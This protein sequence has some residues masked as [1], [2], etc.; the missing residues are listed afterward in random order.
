M[1]KGKNVPLFSLFVANII[2][3]AGSTLTSIAIPWFVLQTTGSVLQTGLTVA[4]RT[5][6]TILS[7][8]FGSFFV[9]R[10][11][12]KHTSVISDFAAGFSIV[13][14][15]VLAHTVGLAFWELLLLVFF[16]S[17]FETP[18]E[19]ARTALLPDLAEMAEMPLVRANSVSQGIGQIARLGGAPLAGILIVLIGSSNLL[20]LDAATFGVSAIVIGLMIPM[21]PRPHKK[22]EDLHY[23]SDMISGVRFIFSDS[24]ILAI[25]IILTVTNMLDITFNSV[26]IPSF[27]K[28]F[29]GTPAVLGLISATFLG[30]ALLG[31]VIFGAI[32]HHLQ[33]RLTLFLGLTIV[34]MRFWVFALFPSL[35][36]VLVISALAGIASAP[37]NPII[38]TIVYERV[39]VE[40]RARVFGAG[41]AISVGGA[42]IGVLLCSY[43]VGGTGMSVGL[44]IM[45]MC[46]LTITLSMLV[47][48]G[49]RTLEKKVDTASK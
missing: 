19:T 49:L 4:C 42:P 26:M 45:G 25:L 2:S 14:I 31:T 41:I 5:I 28:Q 23:I 32:G 47:S 13:L 35:P 8:F 3:Y 17:L 34:S 27:V 11:G 6:P 48:P 15:P 21:N 44:L 20:W 43:L 40:M 16:A 29:F 7:S 39:P 10:L 33:R 30:C 12:Y 1:K 37:L 22:E 9:D 38:N 18:G 24:G 46:Y 36:A